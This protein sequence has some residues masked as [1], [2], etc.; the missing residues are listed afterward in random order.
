MAEPKVG[1]GSFIGIGEQTGYTTTV[2][3][4]KYVPMISDGDSVK[5]DDATIEGGSLQYVGYVSTRY[6]KGKRDV[7]G[8][9]AVEVSYEGTELLWKHLF[10]SVATSQPNPGGQP[11]VYDHLFTLADT[12]PV[13]LTL[14]INRGGT[15]FFVQGAKVSQAEI[16]LGVDELMKLD[17]SFIG[18]DLDTN[19]ASSPSYTTT[20]T[21]ASPD[22]TLQ[23]NGVQ[24]DVR[25]FNVSI[26]HGLDGDRYFIGSKLRK[27]P[28]RGDRLEVTGSFDTEFQ[29]A[30]IFT[31]FKNATQRQL[32]I[33]A[34]GDQIGATGYYYSW[35]MT[36]PIALLGD[37]TPTVSGGGRILFSPS[38][39]AYRTSSANELQLFIRNTV[40]S[41]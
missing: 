27:Q 31:D 17:L 37:A 40:T 8:N 6:R 11:T 22:V 10:G 28:V 39:K 16:S 7:K 32:I 3:A 13:G 18:R 2:A 41:V 25:Q 30:T 1:V 29:D 21:F 38:F 24:Q 5:R 36:I 14:E 26:N 12:L 9:E 15:S 19:T 20:G 34:V 23:W 33:S 35:T 4:S